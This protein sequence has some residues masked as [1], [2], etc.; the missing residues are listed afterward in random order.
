MQSSIE[1]LASGESHK[2]WNNIDLS[3][4]SLNLVGYT[5]MSVVIRSGGT[6]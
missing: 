6:Q 5:Y 3:F 1:D 4:N 2:D